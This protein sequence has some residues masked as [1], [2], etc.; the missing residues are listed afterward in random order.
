MAGSLGVLAVGPTAA[1]SKV[2]DIDGGHP[3]GLPVGPG[4]PT[5]EV[6]DIDGGPQGGAEGMSGS[7]HHRS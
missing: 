3:G 2:G 6:G 1:T 7:G 4:A 5:S